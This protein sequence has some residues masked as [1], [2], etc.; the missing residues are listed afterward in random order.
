MVYK[1]LD[2]KTYLRHLRSVGWNLKKGK[3]DHKL[4]DEHDKFVC[5]IKISHGKTKQEIVARSIHR[6][7]QEFKGRGLAWPPKKK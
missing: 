2:E 7:E 4:Y 1:P 6:T 3:I 5:S